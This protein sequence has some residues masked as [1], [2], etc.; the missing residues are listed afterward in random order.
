MKDIEGFSGLYSITESGEVWSHPKKIFVGKNGGVR[1]Q[2][3]KKLK[4]SCAKK[5]GRH[6]RV[7]L[8]RDGRKY[9]RQVHRLVAEAFLPNPRNLPQVNHIDGNPENNNVSNLEWCDQKKNS[10]HAYDL[11]LAKPPSQT[12]SLNSQAKLTP[13]IV[14]DIRRA[15]AETGNASKVARRFNL[16]PKHAY[17]ICHFRRWKHI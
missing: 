14:L 6:L 1:L 15:F 5:N 4:P 2:P 13:S 3:M 11:G 9:P 12:G 10:K 8:A 16:T 7:Y 17:D